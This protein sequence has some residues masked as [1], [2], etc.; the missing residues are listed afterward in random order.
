MIPTLALVAAPLVRAVRLAVLA[1]L[2]A[3]IGVVVSVCRAYARA[4]FAD[5]SRRRFTA[6]YITFVTLFC[7]LGLEGTLAWGQIESMT[8]D[9]LTVTTTVLARTVLYGVFALG[10]L[11]ALIVIRHHLKAVEADP[12]HLAEPEATEG[13]T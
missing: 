1:I 9:S 6:L 8:N 11:G 13:D 12:D 4:W 10:L 3:S 2:A 7:A 5:R